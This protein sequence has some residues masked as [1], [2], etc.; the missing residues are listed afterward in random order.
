MKKFSIA[1]VATILFTL[2]PLFSA[3]RSVQVL[4]QEI[5]DVQDVGSIKEIMAD[6][7]SK[8]LLEELGE[9]VMVLLLP[10]EQQQA[11][12]DFMLGGE[13]SKELA[14][15]HRWIAYS[16][17]Q[18]GGNLTTTGWNRSGYKTGQTMVGAFWWG[19]FVFLVVLG[20]LVVLV[21]VFAKA[22]KTGGKGGWEKKIPEGQTPLSILKLRYAKGEITKE[23]FQEMKEILLK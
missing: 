15:K 18:N 22:F 6:T 3:S 19:I 13:G 11:L 1:V 2:F 20:I 5:M 8:N 14:A 9:A 16:Y 12:M 7:V 4:M 21:I 23:E 17:L 10:D